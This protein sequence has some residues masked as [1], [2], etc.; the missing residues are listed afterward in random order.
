MLFFLCDEI[1]ELFILS[2]TVERRQR[3]E[4][5]LSR[6]D[7]RF[8]SHRLALHSARYVWMLK[9]VDSITPLERSD[10]YLSAH[11]TV[12]TFWGRFQNEIAVSN[13]PSTRITGLNCRIASKKYDFVAHPFNY[14]IVSKFL[15]SFHFTQSGR[16]T[17]APLF[18]PKWLD[19][20]H[21]KMAKRG[22]RRP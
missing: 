13:L 18:C 10:P 17:R 8:H 6:R 21:D 19:V 12:T 20:D 5:A 4:T 11:P 15:Q 1:I 14:P 7:I 2:T 22:N 16:K 9:S 3:C